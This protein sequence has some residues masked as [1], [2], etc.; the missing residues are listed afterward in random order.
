LKFQIYFRIVRVFNGTL[1]LVLD[2][3]VDI[4][5]PFPLLRAD[6]VYTMLRK[7][8]DDLYLRIPSGYGSA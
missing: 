4:F 8:G 1:F 7:R 6:E 5:K 2:E 3:A